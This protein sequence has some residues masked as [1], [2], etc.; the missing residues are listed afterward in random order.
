M[1]ARGIPYE[2]VR[3]VPTR[4]KHWPPYYSILA[5]VLER[6]TAEHQPWTAQL[7]LRSTD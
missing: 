1:A 3:Y 7:Q 5:N 2:V 6:D 4:F